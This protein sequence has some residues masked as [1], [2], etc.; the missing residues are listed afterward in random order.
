M[1]ASGHP[2]TASVTAHRGVEINC[3]NWLRWS[4]HRE[5]DARKQFCEK[6]SVFSTGA[7]NEFDY[8]TP[9]AP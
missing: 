4:R 9:D 2:Q 8:L 7:A 6:T 1:S 5:T 3:P